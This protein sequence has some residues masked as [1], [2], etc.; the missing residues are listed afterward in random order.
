MEQSLS[1]MDEVSV[2]DKPAGFVDDLPEQSGVHEPLF[3]FFQVLVRAHDAT[4]VADAGGLDPEADGQVGEDG[5]PPFV[6]E[7]DPEQTPVV[8]DRTHAVTFLP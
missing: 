5:F 4:E 3:F 8:A 2:E 7:E 6:V 1:A